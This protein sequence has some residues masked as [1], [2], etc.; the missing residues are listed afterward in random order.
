MSC[1][2]ISVWAKLVYSVK[3]IG[4]N[5]FNIRLSSAAASKDGMSNSKVDTH[6]VS[7]LIVKANSVLC[8]QCG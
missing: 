3:V 1:K 7:S 5:I 2:Q 6:E 4:V 8:V